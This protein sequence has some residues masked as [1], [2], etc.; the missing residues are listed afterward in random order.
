MNVM[1]LALNAINRKIAYYP[2]RVELSLLRPKESEYEIDWL[3]ANRSEGCRPTLQI[4]IS[5]Q[6]HV[7][8]VCFNT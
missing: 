1:S 6:L 4:Y 7:A 3:L 2:R 8:W 5:A